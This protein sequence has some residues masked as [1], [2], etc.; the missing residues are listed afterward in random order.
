MV[1]K[2]VKKERE[3]IEVKLVEKKSEKI[4]KVTRVCLH[5]SGRH[6]R[7]ILVYVTGFVIRR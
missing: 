3:K 7:T 4:K 6:I 5:K 1:G 2:K